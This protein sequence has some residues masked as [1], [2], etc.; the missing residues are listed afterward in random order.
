[1]TLT[2]RAVLALAILAP[3]ALLAAGARLAAAAHPLAGAAVWLATGAALVYALDLLT[4]R[5]KFGWAL[6]RGHG[7][8]VALTFDDGPGRLTAGLLDELD[9]HGIKATFF[10]LGAHVAGHAAL[11]REA[12]ARGHEIGGHGYDHRRWWYVDPAAVERELAAMDEAFARAGLPRPRFVRPPHGTADWRVRRRVAARGYHLV[13]WTRGVWDSKG[14]DARFMLAKATRGAR[15]GE[16]ILLHDGR[17]TAAPGEFFA[18]V[19]GIVTYYRARGFTFVTAGQWW[20]REA[21]P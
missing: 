6:R 13:G 5:F 17:L 15:G 9:R 20:P 16:I 1:M 12:L 18:A 14:R 2:Q 21:G 19:A 8:A 3:L 11:A 7:R 4:V 10:F